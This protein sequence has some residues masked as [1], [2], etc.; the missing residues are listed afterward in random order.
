MKSTDIATFPP[1]V[2]FIQITIKTPYASE[3]VTLE[4]TLEDP[5]KN[6]TALTPS[7]LI[8]QEYTI[9]DNKVLY[10]FPAFTVEPEQC[11]IRYSMSV[12]NDSALKVVSLD[13]DPSVRQFIFHNEVNIALA[14]QDFMQYVVYVHAH[15]GTT[16]ETELEA[17]GQFKL[18][19]KNP[20]VDPAFVQIST[21][22]GKVPILPTDLVYVLFSYDAATGFKF[23]HNAFSVETKPI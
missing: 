12:D 3:S 6:P 8:D 2:Y 16:T 5:C 19:V 15:S 9:T 18:T 7:D 13:S 11:A 23:T 4:V 17:I 20:C 10:Q 22:E 14:G 21:V 1:G